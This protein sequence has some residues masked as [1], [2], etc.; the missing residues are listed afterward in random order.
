L[1][2]HRQAGD[3]DLQHWPNYIGVTISKTI[4]KERYMTRGGKIPFRLPIRDAI[5][6]VD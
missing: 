1:F 2:N 6:E 3:V 4:N 5:G